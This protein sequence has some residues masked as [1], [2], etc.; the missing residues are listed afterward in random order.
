MRTTYR[1]SE[2]RNLEFATQREWLL[3]N[4][5]GG[6]AMGTIS[7]ANTRRY[8]GLLVAAVKPPTYR[9]VLLANLEIDVQGEGNPIGLSCNQYYGALHPEGYQFLEEFSVGKTAFW[10]FRAAGMILEKRVAMHPGVNATTIELYNAGQKPY[11]L[12]LRPLVCHKFYHGNFRF[13]PNYPAALNH[14]R[15]RT[16]VEQDGVALHLSHEGANRHPAVGWYYR[17]EYLRETERGL[18]PRDDLFC[19]CE[20]NYD[21]GPGKAISLVASTEANVKPYTDWAES[22]E[23]L[24][25]IAQELEVASRKFFIETPTRSSILAGFPWF[26][27][28]GRDTMISLPGMCLATGQPA[29]ARKIIRDYLSQM[30][31]GLIPNRFVE[32]GEEPEYNTVDATLWCANAIYKTLLAEWDDEFARD[33]MTALTEVFD[34]HVKG[35]LYGIKVDPADGL[36]T[37]GATGVQLTWMDAKV[38]DWVVTPRHGKPVE[39][40]GLWVNAVRIME[41][42]AEK[43]GLESTRFGQAAGLAESWFDRKFFKET[44]GYYFDTVDPD[45]ASL[46]PN[47]VIAMALP[48]GP[49]KG[50][51]AERALQ[52]V[53]R[54]LLT[55]V[56]LRTL[57]QGS[58][59]YKGRFEGPIIDRDAAYHQGTVWPWLM[60]PYITAMVK[61][62][63]D[64]TEARRLL[65]H[66]RE[67]LDEYG[68]GGIAEVYDGD[69][70]RRPGGCPFQAWSIA[71]WLRAWKE[72]LAT[73]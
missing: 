11:R 51:R 39:I 54:E 52:A 48:F 6:F 31:Q 7:G 12:I 34:W 38:G 72:D 21:L 20:L 57:S 27:D 15:D 16:I 22:S 32:K 56:G 25:S 30:H 9:Q 5:L 3:P 2:C 40:N 28:W 50:P 59:G 35:T 44:L 45:D 53:T 8:H 61:L 42:L 36:L 62:T 65:R 29:L 69:E 71:E 19:P 63:G 10:R 60:G 70:P 24:T 67:I 55:P 47:Q 1:E 13:D 41:W 46:R 37:Q 68:I 26:T 14:H 73:S 66:A 4:G 43:L 17:F 64:T 18:D 58:P 33:A 49:A 23:P